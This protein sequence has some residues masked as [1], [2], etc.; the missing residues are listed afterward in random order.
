[1]KNFTMFTSAMAFEGER[2]TIQDN[3]IQSW[4]VPFSRRGSKVSVTQ[5]EILLLTNRRGVAE[6][7]KRWSCVHVP[8]VRMNEFGTPLVRSVFGRAQA[9]ARHEVMF[10]TNSDILFWMPQVAEALR[11]VSEV[12]PR[13]LMIGRRHDF[14]YPRSIDFAKWGDQKFL[15]RV[16]KEGKL[17][18]DA[19]LDYFGFPKGQIKDVPD[20]YLGCRAWDNAIAHDALK[21]GIPVVDATEVLLAIHIGK[22]T[23]K[24]ITDE[25]RHNRKLAGSAGTWGRTS[26]ATWRLGPYRD[27]YK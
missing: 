19:G 26:F 13:F 22:T 27:T 18:G 5:P 15:H 24:P 12:F 20:Y 10:Y 14:H 6:A 11:R 21:R 1:M 25:I 2:A 8:D 3:A 16:R 9:A 7:A 4:K 17:H 23:N